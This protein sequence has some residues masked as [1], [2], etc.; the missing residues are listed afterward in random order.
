[1][2]R[3]TNTHNHQYVTLMFE[4]MIHNNGSEYVFK[5]LLHYHIVILSFVVFTCNEKIIKEFIG[6]GYGSELACGVAKSAW[7]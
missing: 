6:R 7:D 2:Y 4:H 5:L 3:A 1:M